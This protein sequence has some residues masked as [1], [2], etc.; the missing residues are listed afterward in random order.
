M[1]HLGMNDIEMALYYS[2]D[3][4]KMSGPVGFIIA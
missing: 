4:E 3:W 1:L 2:L